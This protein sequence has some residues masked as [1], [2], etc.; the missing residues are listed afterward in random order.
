MGVSAR[1]SYCRCLPS[2]SRPVKKINNF[3]VPGSFFSSP[4]KASVEENVAFAKHWGVPRGWRA[5]SKAK[6]KVKS[7]WPPQQVAR[8]KAVT[9]PLLSTSPIAH[10]LRGWG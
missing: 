6:L 10:S 2:V 5:F 1:N 4:K 8:K 9:L 3:K 7:F